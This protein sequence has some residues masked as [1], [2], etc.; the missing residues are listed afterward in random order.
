MKTI[1]I[2]LKRYGVKVRRIKE[3]FGIPKSSLY[4]M[5]K[6][7]ED[8]DYTLTEMIKNIAYEFPFYGYRRIHIA[9]KRDGFNINHKKVYRIYR[10]LNLERKSKKKKSFIHPSTSPISISF[11][12]KRNRIWS[13][14]FIHDSLSIGKGIRILI[15]MDIYTRKIVGYRIDRSITGN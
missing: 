8:K 2:S 9:L 4:E 1:I 10:L 3:L 13:M 5:L 7:K 6:D 15:I 12:N 11:P 14:D